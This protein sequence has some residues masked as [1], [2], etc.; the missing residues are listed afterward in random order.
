MRVSG[1]KYRIVLLLL[2][3][4][5]H[6]QGRNNQ[7]SSAESRPPVGI[8]RG[9]SVCA[10]SA[11][12]CHDEK[13]VYYIEA[14]PGKPDRV[15]IRAEKIVN[16]TAITMGSGLWQ[17]NAAKHTISWDS[18]ER[19]WLLNI[20]GRRIDGTLTERGGVVFRRMTLSRDD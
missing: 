9:E 17:Y 20:N 8:W 7:S 6:V 5:L 15:F 4:C 12:S 16:Q 3:G 10:T 14:V 1:A 2:C 18:A 19:L 13:V 11:P